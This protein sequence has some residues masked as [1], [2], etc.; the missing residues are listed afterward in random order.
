MIGLLVSAS[1]CAA[2]SAQPSACFATGSLTFDATPIAICNLA[3]IFTAEAGSP[4]LRL[5]ASLPGSGPYGSG[6]GPATLGVTVYG[7]GSP[8]QRA[9]GQLNL[10]G[11]H[12]GLFGGTYIDFIGSCDVPVLPDRLPI[13]CDLRGTTGKGHALA[14]DLAPA[15]DPRVASTIVWLEAEYTFVGEYAAAAKVEIAV[16]P[17][18]WLWRQALQVRLADG[19]LLTIVPGGNDE[20]RVAWLSLPAPSGFDDQWLAETETPSLGACVVSFAEATPRGSISCPGEP[21]SASGSSTLEMTWRPL[22]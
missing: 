9:S 10:G 22:N 2:P 6:E 8:T 3:T 5:D 20:G 14:W 15:P 19:A 12:G 1:G 16:A 17:G 11:P 18:D 21:S 4:A 7:Y 13:R